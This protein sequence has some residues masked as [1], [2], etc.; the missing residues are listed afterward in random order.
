MGFKLPKDLEIIAN[1]HGLSKSEVEQFA[2]DHNVTGLRRG[3]G[4]NTTSGGGGSK[5]SSGAQKSFNSM[6]TSGNQSPQQIMQQAYATSA[7]T[8]SDRSFY[9]DKKERAIERKEGKI[10]K[11]H[12]KLRGVET[13]SKKSESIQNRISRKQG[14]IERKQ[15]KIDNIRQNG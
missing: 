12:E 11:L 15:R 9:A 3:G 4:G 8:K 13:G 1:E 10:D 5:P 6:T 14:A 2:D 7:A